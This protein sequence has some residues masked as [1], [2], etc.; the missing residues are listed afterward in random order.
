MLSSNWWGNPETELFHCNTCRVTNHTYSLYVWFV[1]LHAYLDID[2]LEFQPDPSYSCK[3]W[4][5]LH[6]TEGDKLISDW[7]VQH[8]PRVTAITLRCPLLGVQRCA[9]VECRIPGISILFAAGCTRC[10]ATNQSNICGQPIHCNRCI[11]CQIL[12]WW[13]KNSLYSINI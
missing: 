11:V 8:E 5:T 12:F 1:T 6:D 2:I 7:K 4:N 13:T 9:T 3:T 10:A